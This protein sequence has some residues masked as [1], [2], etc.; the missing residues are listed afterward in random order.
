MG[1]IVLENKKNAV[2]L[3]AGKSNR[4]APF[5]YEKPKGLLSVKGN[6]LIERQIKYLHETGVSDICVI[7]GY[8]KEKFYYLEQKYGVKIVVNNDFTSK[9]N[10]YS[11]YKVKDYLDNTYICYAD[12]YCEENISLQAQDTDNQSYQTTVHVPGTFREFYVRTSDADVI[13]EVEM[14]GNDTDIMRGFAYFNSGFSQKFREL[15]ETEINDFGTANMFWEEFYAK[16][17]TDLPLFAKKIYDNTVY[18]FDSIDDLRKFDNDFFFNV[19]S[20]NHKYKIFCA[21]ETE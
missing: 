4:F 9:G 3:A 17:I 19:N 2:I 5:T 6:I 13:T 18:E 8:M 10:L 11:L 20:T 21:R 14:G 7:V 1:D 16:N 12:N 15:L